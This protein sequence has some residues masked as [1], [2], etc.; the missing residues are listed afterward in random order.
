M[1]SDTM[2][3][4][5]I[6]V[7]DMARAKKFYGE[8]LGLKPGPEDPGGV[9]FQAGAGTAV[10]LYQRGPSQADHTLASFKVDDAEA[11]V[12][13]LAA[14]GVTFEDYD[15][16]NLKTVNH[17]ATMGNMKGAWFKDPDGNILSLSEM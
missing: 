2:V 3:C 5:T 6:P 17:I 8:T 12:K 10:Y 1:L 13:A 4:P 7:T 9:V 16:P 15:L 11:E 14:K